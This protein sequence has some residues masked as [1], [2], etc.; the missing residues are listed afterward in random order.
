MKRRLVSNNKI[1]IVLLILNTFF[2]IGLTYAYWAS[3]ISESDSV[4]NGSLGIGSWAIPLSTPEDFYDFATKSSSSSDDVY[5]LYSDIDF[6]GFDWTLDETN[7]DV[8]FRGTLLGNGKTLSNLTINNFSTTY[9]YHG[10][11]PIMD[12]GNIENLTLENVNLELNSTSLS[13]TTIRADLIAGDVYNGK[14]NTISMITI[15]DCGVKGT[16]N[17]GV[18]GLV[19]R[20][21]GN[22][23]E[24]H[25]SNIKA[26]NL[27]VFSS[28]TY[29]GG[30]IGRISNNAPVSMIDIDIQGEVYAHNT[31]AYT[32]G[33]LGYI[34]NNTSPLTIMN[35]I[36]EM[37][38]QNTLETDT[39]YYLLY[40]KRYLGGFIGYHSR[41][42][43]LT[44]IENVIFL[45]SLFNNLNN[46]RLDVGT[47]T[48]RATVANTPT[49]TEAYY[50]FVAFRSSSGTIVYTPDGTPTG[51]MSTVVVADDYPSSAWWDSAHA[52]LSTTNP[53]WIQD[54]ITGRPI[55]DLSNS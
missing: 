12:G 33:L 35:V 19:G 24:L 11:F 40:S 26:T 1:I 20:V 46:R 38:S 3:S 51:Q 18:G 47:V 17:N 9:L 27:R 31:A 44:T 37:G 13:V 55:L 23:T 8:V 34:S 50:A 30:L 54:E 43:T 16:S 28:T 39:D 42:G 32:G 15:I 53:L 6:T 48:G 25:I 21:R 7:H 45:G 14:I 41:T 29:A 2:T 10:I 49:I 4:T 22:N 5:Y 36:V 52:V